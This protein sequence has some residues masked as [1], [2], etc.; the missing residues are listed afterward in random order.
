M[1][2]CQCR[3][4]E[5]GSEGQWYTLCVH[6]SALIDALQVHLRLYSAG[7]STSEWPPHIAQCVCDTV[8]THAVISTTNLATELTVLECL[9][10]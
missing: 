7:D 8:Y 3:A 4:C 9:R 10:V 5:S 6:T 2:Q 1:C